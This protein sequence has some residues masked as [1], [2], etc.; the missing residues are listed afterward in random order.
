MYFRSD[1]YMFIL[2]FVY[3]MLFFNL[4]FTSTTSSVQPIIFE[5]K[6]PFIFDL[7]SGNRDIIMW[8]AHRS[9]IREGLFAKHENNQGN[10]SGTFDVMFSRSRYATLIWNYAKQKQ[11]NGAISESE[12]PPR[13]AMPQS[14]RVVSAPIE[15]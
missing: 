9:W 6:H 14:V 5:L 7:I 3:G 4:T 12:A 10:P 11:D 13:H 1:L 15:I 8:D 2:I